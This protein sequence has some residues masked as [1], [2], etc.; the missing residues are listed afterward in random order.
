MRYISQFTYH[1]EA[2]W[3]GGGIRHYCDIFADYQCQEENWF[4]SGGS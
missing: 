2:S 4:H 1:G 3:A